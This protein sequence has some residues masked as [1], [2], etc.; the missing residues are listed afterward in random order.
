MAIWRYNHPHPHPSLATS[1]LSL[2]P[3]CLPP[4]F[5]TL[6]T[7]AT[8][9]PPSM[10]SRKL[11]EDSKGIALIYSHLPPAAC[12][13]SRRQDQCN[14]FGIFHSRLHPRR[15]C[16]TPLHL[17]WIPSLIRYL[18]LYLLLQA[19]SMDLIFVKFAYLLS[20]YVLATSF[21]RTTHPP[22]HEESICSW[23]HDDADKYKHSI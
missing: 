3:S 23:E 4:P 6:A 13:A 21:L 7:H 17:P 14:P 10:P 2:P 8:S 9:C 19:T 1:S 15:T 12:D 11:V 20:T 16:H 18:S 22:G 5:P